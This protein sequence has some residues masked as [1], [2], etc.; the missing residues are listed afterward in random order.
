MPVLR[1]DQQSP[2]RGGSLGAVSDLDQGSELFGTV[3]GEVDAYMDLAAA[4]TTDAVVVRV[5]KG[6]VVGPPLLVVH[7]IDADGCAFFPRLI[8]QAGEGAEATVLDH[9][10]SSPE[11]E[12]LV[13]PV[14]ELDV[15]DAANLSF[16][17]VQALGRKVWQLAALG[18]AAPRIASRTAFWRFLS[19]IWWRRFSPLRGS[20]EILSAG[21]MY[22]QIHSRAAFGYLRGRAEVR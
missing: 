13:A 16:L 22:C 20:T 9:L 4:F 5:P 21:K 1:V 17:A 14:V 2:A 10:A 7:W 12:A 15:G 18:I 8:V 3:A 19:A 6:V 11:A